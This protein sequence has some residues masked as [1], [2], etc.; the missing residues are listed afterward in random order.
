[1]RLMI[2]MSEFPPKNRRNIR[3]AEFVIRGRGF[4]SLSHGHHAST[5]EG[6]GVNIPLLAKIFAR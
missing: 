6:T 4:E 2:R 3:S 5:A 1:M